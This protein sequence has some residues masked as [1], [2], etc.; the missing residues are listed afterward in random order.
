MGMPPSK[1]LAKQ[2]NQPMKAVGVHTLGGMRV[3]SARREM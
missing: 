3:E 1:E 2:F